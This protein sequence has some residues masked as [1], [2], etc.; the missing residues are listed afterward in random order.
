MTTPFSKNKNAFLK[1]LKSWNYKL[2]LVALQVVIEFLCLIFT[3]AYFTFFKPLEI[4]LP[5]QRG[6]EIDYRNSLRKNSTS[7]TFWISKVCIDTLYQ[8][9]RSSIALIIVGCDYFV[10]PLFCV[11]WASL[12]T[13]FWALPNNLKLGCGFQ[14]VNK[15]GMTTPFSKNENAFLKRLKTWNDELD[16]V[17]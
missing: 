8:N 3:H 10:T 2:D 13:L 15:W 17:A 14:F 7:R 11:N 12:E 1:R 16:L 6:D 9:S 4:C 5:K